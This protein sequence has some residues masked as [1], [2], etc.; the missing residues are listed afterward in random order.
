MQK[1]EWIGNKPPESY[2]KIPVFDPL[3]MSPHLLIPLQPKIPLQALEAPQPRGTGGNRRCLSSWGDLGHFFDSWVPL[4]FL[5]FK[6][7]V[8]FPV[9]SL[10]T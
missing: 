7:M 10:G 1:F 2:H 4:V 5:P 6:G 8:F 9:Q 3:Q